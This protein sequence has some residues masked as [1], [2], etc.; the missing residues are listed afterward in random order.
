[1]KD[2]IVST[3]EENEE[4]IVSLKSNDFINLIKRKIHH[5]Q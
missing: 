2:S 5:L 3:D 4:N 1:M